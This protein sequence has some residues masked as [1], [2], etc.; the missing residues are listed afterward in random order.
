MGSTRGSLVRGCLFKNP[1]FNSPEGC[2]RVSARSWFEVSG[3]LN[4]AKD[5]KE[6]EENKPRMDPPSPSLRRGRTQ[7]NVNKKLTADERRFTRIWVLGFGHAGDQF[8]VLLLWPCASHQALES[9]SANHFNARTSV[10][11]RGLFWFVLFSLF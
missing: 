1:A 7:L 4:A 8:G 9:L 3:H 2:G 10:F 11:I 5:R 6:R